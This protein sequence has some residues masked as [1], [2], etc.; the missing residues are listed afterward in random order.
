[1]A[2]PRRCVFLVLILVAAGGQAAAQP[3]AEL[4]AIVVDGRPVSGETPKVLV[5]DKP[6]QAGAELRAGDVVETKEGTTAGLVYPGEDRAEVVMRE[7][8]K[9]E[10]EAS[11][12][13]GKGVFAYFG[14][15]LASVKGVRGKFRVRTRSVTLAIEA[16]L[17]K[18]DRD[19]ILNIGTNRWAFKP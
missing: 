9:V 7:L 2:T 18:Y 1:M 10:I 16:P 19:R 17:G 11:G 14:E 3:V 13:P 5:N 8:T 4:A 12:N 15:I 6:T